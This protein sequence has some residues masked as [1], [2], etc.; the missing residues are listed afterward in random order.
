MPFA[1]HIK[2]K[3]CLVLVLR[4]KNSNKEAVPCSYCRQQARRC[5]IDPKELSQCSEYVC[6]KYLYDLLGLKTVSIIQRRVCRFFI[7]PM[8]KRTA[9]ADP[10]YT[11]C[12]PAFELDFASFKQAVN[13]SLFLKS[14]P[15][16]NLLD[17]FQVAFL[18]LE[19]FGGSPLCSVGSP[20]V[21]I[22]CPF[23]RTFSILQGTLSD[24][25]Q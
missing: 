2:V 21:P 20:L 13:P 8:P 10:P 19:T 22:Y 17:P 14:L 15:D 5:L 11:P 1:K 6:S 9:V 16:F 7:S 4:I 23:R 24:L 12:F 25:S 3:E 18:P